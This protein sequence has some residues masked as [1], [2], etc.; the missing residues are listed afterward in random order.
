MSSRKLNVC[1]EHTHNASQ[2][3]KAQSTWM[4]EFDQEDPRTL[5]QIKLPNGNFWGSSHA[6][7]AGQVNPKAKAKGKAKSRA[8]IATATAENPIVYASKQRA[9]TTRD[10][11]EADRLLQRSKKLAENVLDVTAPKVLGVEGVKSDTT[12]S[13][14]RSR[15]ELVTTALDE[16]NLFGSHVEASRKLFQLCLDDPYLRDCRSSILADEDACQTLAAVRHCRNVTLDLYLVRKNSA[17][18]VTPVDH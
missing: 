6:G 12:L 10:L 17:T 1:S 9:K 16:S 15:L 7:A 2:V 11:H 4:A 3:E 5:V 13:L 8:R 14:L 18:P